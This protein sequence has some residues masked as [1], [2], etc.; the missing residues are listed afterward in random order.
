ML[1]RCFKINTLQKIVQLFH[2]STYAL[3]LV[4]HNSEATHAHM[5]AT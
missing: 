3:P 4:L 5:G 2:S 1:K